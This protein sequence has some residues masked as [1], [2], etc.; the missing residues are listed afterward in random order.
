MNWPYAGM[1]SQ[2]AIGT[3]PEATDFRD[4]W[5][6]SGDMVRVDEDGFYY[7]V[8]RKKDMIVTGGLNVYPA[9]V[10]YVLSSHPAVNYS[11]CHRSAG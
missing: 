5:W 7:V 9:E 1:P 3:S 8:D 6:Y 2:R 10:E 11:L 4:G